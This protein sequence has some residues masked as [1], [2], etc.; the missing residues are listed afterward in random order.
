MLDPHKQ[1][2]ID[3]QYFME[4]LKLKGH[5]VLLLMDAS[6]SEEQT[7]QPH[8]HNTKFV[9]KK[10]FHVD[11]SIDRSLNSFMQNCGLLNIMRQLHEGVVPNTHARG[12][13]HF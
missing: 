9:T 12:S 13:I 7:F 1:T 3:L 6:Q 2:T 5:D 8:I 11:G 10:G 4:D